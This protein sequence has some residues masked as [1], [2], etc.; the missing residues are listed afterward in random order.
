LY[1]PRTLQ[2]RAAFYTK[3]AFYPWEKYIKKLD[4]RDWDRAFCAKALSK[5]KL[6]NPVGA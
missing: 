3:G 6:S 5:S 2:I 1:L 4:L